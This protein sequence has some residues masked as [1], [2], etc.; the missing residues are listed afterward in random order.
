MAT[1]WTLKRRTEKFFAI[2]VRENRFEMDDPRANLRKAL[3][4]IMAT[5]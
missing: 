5:A 2:L 4:P 1:E 3:V